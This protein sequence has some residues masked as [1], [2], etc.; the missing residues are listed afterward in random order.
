MK[1]GD[2]EAVEPRPTGSAAH[3]P[4]EQEAASGAA[5][6]SGT[7][8][9]AES[10]AP[11]AEVALR[12][13][14]EAA[15]RDLEQATA[16]LRA[17]SKAYTELQAEMKTFKERMEARAKQ[18]SELQALDQVRAF[19]DP[20]MNLKRSLG[21]SSHDLGGLLQGLQMV[22]SQFMDALHKLGL[23][24]VPGEGAPFDPRLH[25]ALA[26]QPVT[27]PEQDGKVLVVHT[28]GYTV[29]GRVLQAAQVVIGK[30]VEASGEA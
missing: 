4:N 6:S 14:A 23:S 18:D 12:E 5:E 15:K 29:N 1:V 11:S 19:F 10:E 7:G 2:D 9:S 16:R 28:A 26:V 13:A 30:L 24:D 3:P 27:D 21:A 8:P 25:E 20:V 17:V 22:Q